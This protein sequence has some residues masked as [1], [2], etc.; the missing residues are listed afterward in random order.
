MT[1]FSIESRYERL[2][3]SKPLDLRYQVHHT[4][5]YPY[6]NIG[7]VKTPYILGTGVLISSNLVLT[8]AHIIYHT[9]IPSQIQF[10]PGSNGRKAPFGS[11]IVKNYYMP[12]SFKIND[13][14]PNKHDWAILSIDFLKE[15]QKESHKELFQKESHK[16][17]FQKEFRPLKMKELMEKYPI[18]LIGYP[19][20]KN[21]DMYETCGEIYEGFHD[22]FSYKLDTTTGQSGSAL[23]VR[24]EG[25]CY[26]VGIH[27]SSDMLVERKDGKVVKQFT[28][29]NW[30]IR[31]T[32][33]IKEEIKR[34][35]RGEI[36]KGIGVM[37][38][39]KIKNGLEGK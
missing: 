3:L 33:E 20:D 31:I 15:N 30:G 16:E 17:L 2:I 28:N 24:I 38:E 25:V 9:T 14:Q 27:Q 19:G 35:G 21:G 26:L 22:H 8:S 12:K 4:E 18:S 23:M 36:F 6:C 37:Y 13:K 10:I 29:K 7:I 1:T 34:F 5:E 11:F 39:E 32:K